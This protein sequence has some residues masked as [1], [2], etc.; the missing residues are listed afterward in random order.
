MAERRDRMQT[1]PIDS[2]VIGTRFRV[3]MGDL[4]ELVKSIQEKGVI[5]PITVD[6]NMGLLAGGRRTAAAKLAGLT[7]IPCI[8]RTFVDE[9][10]SREIELIENVARKD[11]TWDERAKLVSQIDTLYK[12][13]GGEGWDK[14][15]LRKTAELL[16]R[17]PSAVSRDLQLAEAMTFLPELAK[18][19][20]ADEAFKML[21]KIEEEAIIAE[22]ASRQ[23]EMVND[24]GEH[25][26]LDMSAA[27]KAT[28][29]AADRDYKIGDIF[30]NLARI[31]DNS[32]I[33]VIECDPPYGI[34]LNQQKAGRDQVGSSV[35]SYEEV[36]A[37]DYPDFL[38][39]LAKELF[40]VAG[41]NCWL[42]FWFGPTW[43]SQVLS[44]L[45]TA[46]WEV[47]IIPAIWS[48][49]Y[50]QTLQPERYLAR[51][52]EPFYLCR[53][54]TPILAHRGRANVFDV[55]GLQ[56]NNKEDPKYHPTQRPKNLIIRI[57]STL[58]VGRMKVLVPFAG[59]GATLRAC[60]DLGL[61]CCGYD[62]NAEYKP[63]FLLRVEEETR[64]ALSKEVEE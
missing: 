40:R 52:Y 44:S 30:A 9:I 28:L 19:K 39:K 23:T 4:D 3:D 53:K 54:G 20:T 36:N 38:N 56:A 45:Q 2:I 35:T 57:L 59:S 55:P 31:K 43:Q 18:S 25:A 15:S 48:K 51:T 1:V 26:H 24:E 33:D 21:K 16:D 41:A 6:S 49:G 63:K 29:K 27:I 62:I 22:L 14:W 10:D 32:N 47:D 46:G 61:D 17:S 64:A 50:G 34:A 60:Y 5:Q 8:I 37:D 7:K 12:E 11:F 42:V 13:K 58:T